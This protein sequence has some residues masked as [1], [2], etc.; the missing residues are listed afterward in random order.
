MTTGHTE[1]DKY[2]WSLSFVAHAKHENRKVNY[3]ENLL[4]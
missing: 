3:K 2:L 4:I 1:G